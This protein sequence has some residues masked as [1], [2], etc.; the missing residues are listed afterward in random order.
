MKKLI[1]AMLSSVLV[2]GAYAETFDVSVSVE[3][4]DKNIGIERTQGIAFPGLLVNESSKVGDGCSSYYSSTSYPQYNEL[5]TH[6]DESA[7]SNANFDVTGSPHTRIQ[8]EI[9]N[10]EVQN[11]LKL[12]LH[13][14]S[15]YTLSMGE[16][17]ASSFQT[18]GYLVVDNLEA[19]QAGS[20]TFT[21]TVNLSYI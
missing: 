21:Y 19:V 8:V 20:T 4:T 3:T 7:K 10:P 17:G 18:Y 13:P 5:C 9:I 2:S 6:G 16:T 11:G 12:T 14:L 15:D 1:T